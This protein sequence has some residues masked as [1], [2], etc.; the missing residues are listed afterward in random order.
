MLKRPKQNLLL[1]VNL[2]Q[3]MNFPLGMVISLEKAILV[4]P[5]FQTVLLD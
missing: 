1:R 5:P 4:L 3:T 2:Y